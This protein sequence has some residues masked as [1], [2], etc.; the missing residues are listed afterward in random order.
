M[1]AYE[2]YEKESNFVEI[3]R[4]NRLVKS[5]LSKLLSAI[6]IS[7]LKQQSFKKDLDVP[8]TS[9]SSD[10]SREKLQSKFDSPTNLFNA[11]K[12]KEF[13]LDMTDKPLASITADFV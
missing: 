9:M 12:D 1:Q 6:E 10:K 2:I 5:A 7:E 13:N 8:E 4:L 3:I 11:S